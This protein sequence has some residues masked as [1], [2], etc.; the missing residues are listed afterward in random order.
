VSRDVDGHRR[1]VV[2]RQL[3]GQLARRVVTRIA[4]GEDV[5]TGDRMGLMKFGSRMDIYH[6]QDDEL[7]VR[8]GQRAVAGMTVL[9]RFRDGAAPGGTA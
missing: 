7:D 2:F 4:R 6:P 8:K 5:A 3:V 9:G 1:T